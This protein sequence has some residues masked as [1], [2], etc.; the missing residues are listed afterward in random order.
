MSEIATFH[1]APHFRYTSH[2]ISH[3]TIIHIK[4]LHTSRHTIQSH[5][6][7]ISP[8][9]TPCTSPHSN[10][11]DTSHYPTAHIPNHTTPHFPLCISAIIPH[12][13]MYNMASDHSTS[14]GIPQPHFTSCITAHHRFHIT[15]TFHT[16][17]DIA[18]HHI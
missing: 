12:D 13:T 6:A 14:L 5:H 15:N 9:T 10:I 16:S 8:C 7:H 11:N 17:S 4:S 2:H 1:I 3:R 18:R